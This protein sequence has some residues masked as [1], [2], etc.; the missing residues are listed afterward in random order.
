[1]VNIAQA[2]RRHPAIRVQHHDHGN[3]RPHRRSSGQEYD[4]IEYGGFPV[5]Y[6]VLR[7]SYYA[8]PQLY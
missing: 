7:W 8:V 3:P 4:G 6:I 1:M 5:S 2:G